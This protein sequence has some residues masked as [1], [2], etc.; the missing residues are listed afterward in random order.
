[1]N[2]VEHCRNPQDVQRYKGEPYVSAADVYASPLQT[3]QSGWT[4]YT[5]SAAWMHRVWIEE[6]LG[7]Q[8]RGKSFVIQ[9]AIPA[10]WNEFKMTYRYENT[11]YR[12][13][14]LRTK[15][16]PRVELDGVVLPDGVVPLVGG[17]APRNV[18]VYMKDA[19]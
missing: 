7:F 8:R 16:S 17:G 12:I 3:G 5:G 10:S 4:W 6:V 19:L 9:P 2:P 13:S 1:M 11:L 15:G 18:V 14:V